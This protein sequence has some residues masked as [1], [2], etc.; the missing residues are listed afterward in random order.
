MLSGEFLP[1]SSVLSVPQSVL[2]AM[3]VTTAG[4]QFL[5]SQRAQQSSYSE[6]TAAAAGER[7]WSK[8]GGTG[9]CF[10]TT[11]GIP[12]LQFDIYVR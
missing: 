8:D 6:E 1:P 11:G 9:R 7:A 5:H 2:R 4:G 3:L 10:L 12:A